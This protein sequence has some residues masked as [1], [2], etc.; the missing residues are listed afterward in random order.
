[1]GIDQH[2]PQN[3]SKIRQ[4]I[5][6]EY[7]AN[8]ILFEIIRE[9]QVNLN[10]LRKFNLNKTPNEKPHETANQVAESW[11]FQILF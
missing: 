11:G 9:K 2:F 5:T 3:L 4:N 10:L 8:I 6:P 7:E 1:M